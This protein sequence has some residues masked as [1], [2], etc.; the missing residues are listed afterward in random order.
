MGS[1]EMFDKIARR[2]DWVNRVIS[3]GQDERWRRKAIRAMQLQDT[4]FVLDLATGN[5]QMSRSIHK[6]NHLVRI[7]GLDPSFQ[8]LHLGKK[9]LVSQKMEW[10]QGSAEQL[11]FPSSQ[12]DAVCMAFGIRNVPDRIKALRE[13]ERVLKPGGRLAILELS[14]P[15]NKGIMDRLS[16]FYIRWC[17]PKIG[18]LLSSSVEYDYLQKSVAAFPSPESFSNM[19]QQ[20]G[21]AV[22]LVKPLT[23]GACQLYV[24]EKPPV[25]PLT[26]PQP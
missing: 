17:L 4:S 8:M 26:P 15:K 20:T 13:I 25:V 12:F 6:K 1:G 16:R 19:I 9:K 7:I 21:L 11:P 3:V 2:Y 23:W 10:V 14:M 22:T 5:G 18:A 24:A